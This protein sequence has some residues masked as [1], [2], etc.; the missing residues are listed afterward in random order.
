[1][2]LTV[3]FYCLKLLSHH[4]CVAVNTFI[5][6]CVKNLWKKK[7]TGLTPLTAITFFVRAEN[8]EI[9]PLCCVLRVS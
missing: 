4:W 9:V 1:M 8:D 7:R 3:F 6:G 2:R 5:L